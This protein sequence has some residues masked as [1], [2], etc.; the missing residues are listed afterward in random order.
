M[1][2]I[3]SKQWEALG[4]SLAEVKKAKLNDKQMLA[5]YHYLTNGL[6]KSKAYRDAGYKSQTPSVDG[7][8]LLAQPS[9]KKLLSL[10]IDS[11]IEP[12]KDEAFWG[13]V[14]RA[15]AIVLADITDYTDSNG[16]YIG[17]DELKKQG[18]DT[19]PI[20]GF[21][22]SQHGMKVEFY[23]YKEA[24]E[25]LKTYIDIARGYDHRIKVEGGSMEGKTDEELEEIL[26]G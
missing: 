14:D 17:K 22:P 7:H 3:S 23:S 2:T 8:K 15:R 13:I 5:V 12:L 20:K 21:T 24:A 4:L 10:A 11:L 18:I 1:A 16:F 26:E 6:N 19:R 25:V 9:V